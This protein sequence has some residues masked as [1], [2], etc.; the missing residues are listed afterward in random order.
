MSVEENP[1]ANLA[2]R[3]VSFSMVI[4]TERK[5]PAFRDQLKTSPES[6]IEEALLA[7]MFA[8][9]FMA[10]FDLTDLGGAC[11]RTPLLGKVFMQHEM[12][13][14][15]ADFF[16]EVT[17]DGKP[18]GTIVVECDGHDFH[19]RTKEQAARDRSRDRVM[20]AAGHR[21]LRF[22]GSELWESA[23]ECASEIILMAGK[24]VEA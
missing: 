11:P 1:A 22:T 5:W 20:T 10:F 23:A 21:V 15:R 3:D 17:N 18:I 6:P 12:P 7:A 2:L 4:A 14:W 24:M 9:S 13:P 19:E 8:W 16:V